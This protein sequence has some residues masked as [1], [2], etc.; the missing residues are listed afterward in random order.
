MPDIRITVAEKT[1]RAEG[2]PEIICGNADYT[3]VF[4]F[5]D[6]WEAYPVKTL[7]AVWRSG[8]E[9]LYADVIF[10]GDAVQLPALYGTAE[11][12]LGVFAGDIRTTTPARIPCARCITDSDPQHPDP[13][14]DVYTQ[15]LEYLSVLQNGEPIAC[16]DVQALS[17]GGI[18][19][20]IIAI[21]E[22]VS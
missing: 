6:E 14:P 2:H 16:A 20:D 1:A 15:L 17:A 5:D 4:D 9:Y 21:A 8:G 11:V 19:E 18:S 22:E 12:A 3:A 7:R 13:P 10:E